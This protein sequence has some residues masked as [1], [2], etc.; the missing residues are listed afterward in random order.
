MFRVILRIGNFQL[1][2]WGVMVAIGFA[3]GLFVASRR[4]KKIGVKPDTIVDLGVFLI[5]ASLIGSRFW[6]VITHISEFS[7]NYWNIINPFQNGKI[8]ISGM[9]MVGGVIFGIATVLIFCAIK[10]INFLKLIDII[11]PSFLLG[12]FL[13]R[14]GCFLNGCCFGRECNCFWGISY[15]PNSPAGYVFSGIPIHPTQLYE[16]L[17]NLIFFIFV[18][19]W[20]PKGRKFYGNT[21]WMTFFL[22]G[23]GRAFV[24]YFRYYEPHEIVFNYLGGNISIHGLFVLILSCIALIFMVFKIGKS[25]QPTMSKNEKSS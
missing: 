21:F 10:K 17:L 23:L 25:I 13:G 18:I 19:R 20:E 24:D 4:A 8:G 3:A 15:P 11:A 16:L 9:A 22:Y 5:L 2:T 1:Y 14:I 7:N 12:M 6:Y